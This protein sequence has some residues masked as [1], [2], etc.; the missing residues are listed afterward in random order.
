MKIILS[1]RSAQPIYEQIKDQIREAILSGELKESDLLPS[2]RGLARDLKVSVITT[3]RAFGDL[4]KEGFVVN[5]QGKGCY[6]LPRNKELARENAL[7]QVEEALQTAISAAKNGSIT[8]DEFDS[9]LDILIREEQYES[10]SGD[11]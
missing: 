4:E 11:Q 8:R 10:D 9:I 2:V 7:R 6:V 5:V 1:N 3:T